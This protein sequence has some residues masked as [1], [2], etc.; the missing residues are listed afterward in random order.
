M[1]RNRED[2]E[3]LFPLQGP[4]NDAPLLRDV[5]TD[6]ELGLFDLADV[7][8]LPE[9]SK[10]DIMTAVEEFFRTAERDDQ[11]LLYYSG[12][13]LPDINANLYLCARDTVTSSLV[14]TGISDSEI[15]AR[16]CRPE[17]PL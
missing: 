14:A 9:R 16:P 13:G 6:P 8:L 3:N 2:P 15:K 1:R 10:R 17:Q 7:R 11:L 12:H 5:L 4:V